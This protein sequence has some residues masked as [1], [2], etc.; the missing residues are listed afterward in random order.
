[1][2]RSAFEREWGVNMVPGFVL[3]RETLRQWWWNCV[4]EIQSRRY[5]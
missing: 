2:V 5:F 4:R 3:E 1:M